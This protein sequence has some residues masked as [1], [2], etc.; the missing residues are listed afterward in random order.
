MKIKNLFLLSIWMLL[1]LACTKDDDSPPKETPISALNFK[2]IGEDTENVFQYSHASTPE[3]VELINLSQENGIERGYISLR[4]TEDLVTFYSFSDG[5][6]SAVQRNVVTG[7][8]N[9]FFEFYSAS[10]D[11]STTW[12][13]NS[14]EEAFFGFFPGTTRNF[15]ILSV[16]FETEQLEETIISSDVNR[17]FEP[18]FHRDRLI[19]T[20]K[21]DNNGFSVLIFDTSSKAVIETFNFGTLTPSIFIDEN[22]DIVLVIGQ[23]NADYEYRIYDIDSLEEI[24]TRSF[25]LLSFF[26]AG[27]IQ[28]RLDAEK[29]F[30]RNF[31][32]QPAPISYG[33][34][35]Y[36]F[37]TKENFVVDMIGIKQ[38]AETA[39]DQNITLSVFNYDTRNK[40]FLV[41]YAKTA[42]IGSPLEGGVLVISENGS[43]QDNIQ[44]DFAPTFF[45][46]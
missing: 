35:I 38:E 8:S 27:P 21:G 45:I 5:E 1:A 46:D 40:L 15:G 11:K 32:V 18:I 16:N 2:I 31:Y 44:L 12:G 17:V 30:Y 25:T 42:P 43:L 37:V 24:E 33:P 6:F 23:N 29:L 3:N 19:I 41:G 26:D 14:R 9:A 36:D 22:D 7:E 4:Q 34:G 28:A 13:I 39:L 10:L 20:L